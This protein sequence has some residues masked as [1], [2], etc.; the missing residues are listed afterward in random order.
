[1]RREKEVA[2]VRDVLTDMFMAERR[3]AAKAEADLD[4][5]GA[6]LARYVA[7]Y[8]NARQRARQA[9]AM[10]AVGL[11]LIRREEAKHDATRR[12]AEASAAKLAAVRALAASL[13]TD[14]PDYVTREIADEI[15]AILGD[16]ETG[17]S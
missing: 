5:I 7:A 11:E 10:W 12:R 16:V 6:V 13:R 8:G 2:A 15:D 14:R 3:R 1:M 9:R 4:D 17:A